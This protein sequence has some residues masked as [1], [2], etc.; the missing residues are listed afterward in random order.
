MTAVISEQR[1]ARSLISE[2]LFDRLCRKIVVDKDLD[3]AF[4]ERIMDQALAFL[5]AC[6]R[7]PGNKLA[8]SPIVDIGWHAFILYTR[9]YKAFCD[10]HAGRFI[11]HIPED[12]LGAPEHSKVPVSVR[13][14]TVETIRRAGYAVDPELWIVDSYSCGTCHEEGNCAASGKSG[15]ENTGTRIN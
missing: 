7:Y 2:D 12:A 15:D 3:R 8:P 4:T 9:E 6:A 1:Q 5:G 14:G 13:E 11:H 10:E